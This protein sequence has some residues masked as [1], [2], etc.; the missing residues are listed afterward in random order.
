[1]GFDPESLDSPAGLHEKTMLRQEGVF[2][3]P[4]WQSGRLARILTICSARRREK[5]SLDGPSCFPIRPNKTIPNPT[6]IRSGQS[7]GPRAI[8]GPEP[9]GPLARACMQFQLVVPMPKSG[10]NEMALHQPRT[11]EVQAGCSLKPPFSLGDLAS[12]L[13]RSGLFDSGRRV[14]ACQGLFGHATDG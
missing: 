9:H 13:G 2:M 10:S 12:A 5:R 4:H 3:G 1:M 7:P 11:F 6:G 8:R 14:S